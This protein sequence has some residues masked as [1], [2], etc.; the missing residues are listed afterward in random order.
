MLLLYT[1]PPFVTLKRI[2]IT[3][4]KQER[5]KAI[6]T[7]HLYSTLSFSLS[8]SSFSLYVYFSEKLSQ[9]PLKNK[10]RVAFL[11]V[12]NFPM[13]FPSNPEG[14][15]VNPIVILHFYC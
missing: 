5:A 1:Y 6:E 3:Q 11:G 15:Q 8:L 12:N 14:I 13:F 9:D 2:T 7:H 4:P 10:H